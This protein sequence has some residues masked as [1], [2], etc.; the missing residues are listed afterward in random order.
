MNDTLERAIETCR[1][2]RHGGAWPMLLREEATALV[3]EIERLRAE[4]A[5]LRK[6]VAAVRRASSYL[7]RDA[8]QR[9]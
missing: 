6:R 7:I 4:N 1:Q 2:A 8:D 3:C 5:M 9:G